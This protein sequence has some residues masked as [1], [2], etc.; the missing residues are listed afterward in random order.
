MKKETMS[1]SNDLHDT[2]LR[3]SGQDFWKTCRSYLTGKLLVLQIDGI[4]DDKMIAD[5]FARHLEK[6]C[7]PFSRAR[8]DDL[9]AS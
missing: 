2:L 8:N 6:V 1:F 3:K 9:K 7:T 5:N 4:T